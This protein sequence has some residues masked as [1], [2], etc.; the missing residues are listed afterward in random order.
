MKRY[1]VGSALAMAI[2]GSLLA[3]APALAQSTPAQ[4]APPMN[5]ASSPRDDLTTRVDAYMRAAV[6]YE[7]FSGSILIARDGVTLV[8]TGYGMASYELGVPNTSRTVFQTASIT[9]SFTAMAI[10]QLRDRGRL[11]VDDPICR[12]LNNCPDAWKPVTIRHLLT[13]TS[14]IKNFT[15]LPDWDESLSFRSYSRA[16]VVDLFRGLPLEFVPGEKFDYSNSGFYLLG[17]IVERVSG[18]SYDQF[19]KTN[20][21]EP[22]GMT[23]TRYVDG[24]AVVPGAATGYYSRGTAFITATYVDPTTSFG[25][26]GIHSTTGDLLKWDQALYT[27]K[28][29]SRRSLE[30]IF[31]PYKP[32]YGFGWELGTRFGKKTI[33]HAGND[34]GFS[35]YI[36]RIPEEKL[37]V[38]VLGNSDKMSAGRTGN[39]LAAIVLGAPY[40]I[41]TQHLG[42]ALWETLARDGVA[43]ATA[44]FDQAL[45]ATP[46]RGDANDE[47][48][49]DL[50]YDLIADRRLVEAEAIFRF[51]LQRFPNL[52]YAWD[53][54]ADIAIARDDPAA[55]TG[56]FERSL[57]LDPT[58]DYAVR[59]LER[60]RGTK[61][62]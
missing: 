23:Q 34:A 43:A 31:T 17:L 18:S 20:I 11:N 16:G 62:S 25:A 21:F 30:E 44:R 14:G 61:G 40:K 19:L 45:R 38:I 35:T 12:Y 37:T 8:D 60:L 47:T 33:G 22:L 28:L 7:Q 5:T 42:D 13:H 52:A 58:N 15:R 10:I 49:L 6:A 55:A 24:R 4:S 1:L 36:L 2:T 3:A 59:G 29:V 39:T 41:P 27:E 56:F 57:K 54:L 50:G 9:K 51:A 53:G 26:S 32:E 46:K 48:L